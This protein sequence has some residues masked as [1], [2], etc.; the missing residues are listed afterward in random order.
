M[1]ALARGLAQAERL[2]DDDSGERPVAS[3]VDNMTEWLKRHEAAR[4]RDENGTT[5]RRWTW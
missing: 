1:D 4:E 3:A 2:A 5:S